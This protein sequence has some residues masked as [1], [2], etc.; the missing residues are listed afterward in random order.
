M[1]VLFISSFINFMKKTKVFVG[2]LVSAAYLLPMLAFAQNGNITS[3]GGLAGFLNSLKSLMDRIVPLLIGLAVIAF[4][5]G[6]LRF[7]FNAGNE[8]ARKQG[9][10]FIIYGLIGIVVMI[11]VWGLVFFV[12]NSLGLNTSGTIVTPPIPNF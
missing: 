2:S 10:D 9:K 1:T 4:L 8:D 3:N 5:Y 7:V 11:S 12:Q 6:V